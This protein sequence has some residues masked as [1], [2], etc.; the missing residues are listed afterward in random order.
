MRPRARAAIACTTGTDSANESRPLNGPSTR[1]NAV[2]RPAASQIGVIRSS[3]NP[4]RNAVAALA[5]RTH[6]VDMSEKLPVLFVAHG[7]PPLLDDAGW[8]GELRAWGE[9]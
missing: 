8:L 5:W 3:S 1:T 4:Y 9:A 7:A 6:I 2:R